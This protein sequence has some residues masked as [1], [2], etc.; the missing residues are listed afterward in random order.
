MEFMLLVVKNHLRRTSGESVGTNSKKNLRNWRKLLGNA[1]G[2]MWRIG[3]LDPLS[4]V[5]GKIDSP[6]KRE[7]VT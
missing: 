6:E 7:K 2:K 3:L 5:Y 1:R 4:I